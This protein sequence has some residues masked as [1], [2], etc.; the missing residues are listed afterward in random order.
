MITQRVMKKEEL[1]KFKLR[2]TKEN[3]L[4]RGVKRVAS[5]IHMPDGASMTPETYAFFIAGLPNNNNV[6]DLEVDD[7]VILA[8]AA[9][10]GIPLSD[11]NVNKEMYFYT[12]ESFVKMYKRDE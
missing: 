9:L 5:N 6:R 12:P 1:F 10:V 2:E 4:I 3:V 11:V 7:E 8:Y